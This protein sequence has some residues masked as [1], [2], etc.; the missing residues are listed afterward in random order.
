MTNP[1]PLSMPT[2]DLAG[3]RRM[4]DRTFCVVRPPHPAVS[5]LY[6]ALSQADWEGLAVAGS[7]GVITS[8]VPV[9]T[10]ERLIGLG[11]VASYGY[12]TA[13]GYALLLAWLRRNPRRSWWASLRQ[14]R[15]QM[16]H[17]NRMRLLI[18][19]PILCDVDATARSA[20]L[21]PRQYPPRSED[22]SR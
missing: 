2:V 16:T 3:V 19:A 7:E 12:P 1:K 21:R 6:E 17:E 13:A 15:A 9:N 18:T 5:D 4:P 14:S 22:R 20:E 11:V 8:P 10:V